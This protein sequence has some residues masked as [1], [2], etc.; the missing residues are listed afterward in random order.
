MFAALFVFLFCLLFK[1]EFY[2]CF[3]SFFCFVCFHVLHLSFLFC[4]ILF[5]K[6]WLPAKKL[7]NEIFELSTF[8]AAMQMFVAAI[9]QFFKQ[10]IAQFFLLHA[11]LKQHLFCSIFCIHFAHKNVELQQNPQKNI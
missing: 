6:E 4:L 9:K 11:Q 2:L 3:H 1:V 5:G 8:A 10:H 7:R